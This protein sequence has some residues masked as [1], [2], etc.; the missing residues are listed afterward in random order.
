MIV[1]TRVDDLLVSWFE[2]RAQGD[3][4][5]VAELCSHCPE[6]A[7]E[8]A[9]AIALVRRTD[10]LFL[11]DEEQAGEST[12]VHQLTAAASHATPAVPE[13]LSLVTLVAML[14]EADLV[15]SDVLDQVRIACT[16]ANPPTV[17]ETI[18]RLVDAGHLTAFQVAYICR[19]NV[20]RLVLGNYVLLD[21]LGEGGMGQVYRARH[22][23]MKREVAVKVLPDRFMTS[24]DAV[25]R[26]RHEVEAAARLVHPNVVLAYDADESNGRH[27]LVMECVHGRDLST[28]VR[29]HGPL[30]VATALD[31]VIQAA[32][33]LDYAHK[34]GIV[35][36]DI[37]P[38]NLLHEEGK[39]VVK[40]LDLGLALFRAESGLITM[41]EPAG[42]PAVMGTLHYM[43]PEQALENGWT[44]AR[45][46]IYALGCTLYYLLTG[47]PP[48][49]QHERLHILW[50]HQN[51]PAPSLLAERADVPEELEAVYQRMMA[52]LP[53]DRYQSMAE[54]LLALQPVA[55]KQNIE[56][57]SPAEKTR[58]PI[59]L[60][61]EVSRELRTSLMWATALAALVLVILGARF[62][63]PMFLASPAENNPQNLAEHRRL[64]AHAPAAAWPDQEPVTVQLELHLQRQ[65][66]QG[67]YRVLAPSDGL[68]R[69]G[70]RLHVHATASRPAYLYVFWYDAEGIATCVWPK[71]FDRQEQVQE[72]WEPERA[73]DQNRQLWHKL[74]GLP[75]QEMML[76]CASDVPLSQAEVQ[77]LTRYRCLLVSLTAEGTLEPIPHRVRVGTGLVQSSKDAEPREADRLAALVL[78]WPEARGY[79]EITPRVM[80][81]LA[82]DSARQLLI[83]FPLRG[84]TGVV[85]SPK[86]LELSR[87]QRFEALVLGRF[88]SYHGV[89]FPFR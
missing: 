36:R 32:R 40:V 26:F 83:D 64:P 72:I 38:S 84:S 79:Y 45:S 47:R 49:S 67:F 1:D 4:P 22:R 74:G 66:E 7:G 2:L 87:D 43:A 54:V 50:A 33:G 35:H 81:T 25:E 69:T 20:N 30:S 85:S 34:Q 19:N 60:A 76:A 86:A 29:Q 89:L 11:P 9:E 12:Q 77:E 13:S 6:L 16:Q 65:H 39:D 42:G 80:P 17:A 37:K 21:K 15:P 14:S 31:A 24:P 44:D 8:L 28:I 53:K 10:F 57:T 82:L 58:Q 59:R 3:E 18:G 51:E 5:N 23:R 73:D 52:K 78:P 68:V 27:Y 75:G 48:Y 56:T 70:D 62:I 55:E 61:S 46:D 63:G 88:V 71:D 41:P